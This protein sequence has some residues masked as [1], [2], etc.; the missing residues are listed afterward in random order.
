M[1]RIL[2]ARA[3]EKKKVRECVGKRLTL[4]K[5]PTKDS[6]TSASGR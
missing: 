1:V 4:P 6:L 2:R 3:K 5:G